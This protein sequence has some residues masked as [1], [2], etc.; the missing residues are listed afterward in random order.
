MREEFA[1]RHV[2][3]KEIVQ[4]EIEGAPG[5][6][7]RENGALMNELANDRDFL[8]ETRLLRRQTR[9]LL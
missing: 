5:E 4:G 3:D 2:A 6:D 1:E 8:L 9:F 7:S